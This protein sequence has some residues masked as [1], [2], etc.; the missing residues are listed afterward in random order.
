MTTGVAQRPPRGWV[1]QFRVV[2]GFVGLAFLIVFLVPPLSTMAVRYEFVESLQFG[3]FAFVVPV[4]IVSSAPWRRLRLASTEDHEVDAD[5]A[6][7]SPVRPRLVDRVAISR[8]KSSHQRRAVVVAIVFAA[9][10]VF[11][12]VAPVVDYLVRHNW[13]V[14]IEALTLLMA[15]IP[16][17]TNLIESPPMA[18]GTLRPYRIGISA[19][20]MWVSWIV[21]YLD[22]MSHDSWYHAFR[23]IAGQGLSLAADQQLSA[24]FIWLVSA[25]VFVPI[26]FWNL[27]HWLHSDEDPND[28][29]QRLMRDERTRGFFGSN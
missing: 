22:G 11:W 25:A 19:G 10:T 13:L 16:L 26:I 18:P 6:R 17:F 1:P 12:R 14:S 28:E 20:V 3:V 9:V 8:I 2:L 27:V 24:G 21:A 29:L 5:G 7:I 15:G 4:L 23:H